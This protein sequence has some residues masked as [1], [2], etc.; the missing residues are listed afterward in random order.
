MSYSEGTPDG[1]DYDSYG[2]GYAAN[3]DSGTQINVRGDGRSRIRV[4]GRD[5]N[6]TY[7]VSASSAALTALVGLVILLTMWQPWQTTA[8]T[9]DRNDTSAGTSSGSSGGSATNPVP[10]PDPTYSDEDD[11]KKESENPDPTP[12]PTPSPTPDPPPDRVD[13]A[14]ASV[15]VGTCLNVYD[16]GWGKLN[17]DRPSAVDCGA[18]YAYSKVTAVT[19]S[20]SN[21]P[22]S[23]GRRSWGH[24]NDDGTSIALCLDR[25]FVAGQ[26]FPAKLNRQA[27]GTLHGE[28]RLF[29]VWGCDETQVPSGLNAV[30]VITAVQSGGSCPR[31]N[32]RQTLS[33][34]IFNGA[35]KVCAVQ[36]TN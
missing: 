12:T 17:H 32:D 2:D 30:M 9:D 28:A 27:D 5:I 1:S 14:F 13:V 20:A 8:S 26:C 31:R 34:E 4:A 24:V 15:G 19:T 35:G 11:E 21:C 25:V 23:T 36:R 3:S 7:F 22:Q 10:Q 16:E 29:S 33:W 6:S 18:S